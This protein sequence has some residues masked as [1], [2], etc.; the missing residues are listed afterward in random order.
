[1]PECLW[2]TTRRAITL[3]ALIVVSMLVTRAVC[4]GQQDV[5]DTGSELSESTAIYLPVVIRNWPRPLFVGLHA[6]WDGEGYIRG[7]EHYNTGVHIQRDAIEMTDE[8]VIRIYG[9]QWYDPNPE[10]WESETWNEYYSVS[11]G[12]RVAASIEADPDWKWGHPW[13]LPYFWGFEDGLVGPIGGQPFRVSGP[14]A[15]YTAFGKRV[16]Y[17]QFVN[18]T[19]FVYWDAGGDWQQRVHP[20]DITLRYDAG[21][22]RLLLYSN[23]LRRDYYKAKL[24]PG[25]VQYVI[26]LTATNAFERTSTSDALSSETAEADAPVP[27][28]ETATTSLPEQAGPLGR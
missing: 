25:T 24:M 3:C 26:S 16:T 21:K 4:A 18:T 7:D 22:T 27:S 14:Y 12:Y 9:R 10:A 28:E 5:G 23:V 19:E 11:T 20:G 15:G 1:M 17:W 6:R 13:V 2:K 8:D